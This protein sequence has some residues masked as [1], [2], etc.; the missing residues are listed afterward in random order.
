MIGVILLILIILGLI[1][2]LNIIQT[3][4]GIDCLDVTKAAKLASEDPDY[5]I[6]DLYEA[7][8]RGNFVR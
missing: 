5:G 4:Q 8:A 6:R 3:D 1:P 7:I 2:A